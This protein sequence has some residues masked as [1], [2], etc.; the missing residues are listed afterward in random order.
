MKRK[1]LSIKKLL[2]AFFLLVIIG[3]ASAVGVFYYSLTPVSE[4]QEFIRWEITEGTSTYEIINNLESDGLIRNALIFKLYIK[5][6]EENLLIK[7]GTY[8]LSP[9]MSVQEIITEFKEENYEREK[10]ITVTFKEGLSI[11][12]M[13][14]VL[15][16]EMNI[17]EEEV[18]NAL[19]DSTYLD[20]LIEKHW[21]LTDEIK[22]N[23]LYY[24]LEGY[25]FPNTYNFYENSSAKDVI[26]KM[27]QETDRVLSKYRESI[28]AGK[29]SVHQILTLASIIQNEGTDSNSFKN[30]SSVLYNRL[31]AGQKL[32]CCT[33]AYYGAKLIQGEDDF[34]NA[35]QKVNAYNTYVVDGIP[36]GPISN[37][38]E[39]AIEAAVS[40]AKTNYYYFLSDSYLRLYFSRTFNEH[41]N[42]QNE[43]ISK[44]MWAGS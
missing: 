42:K 38:G 11:P 23:K 17:T 37:P 26:N 8:N 2:V 29:Y 15:K 1:R 9:S 14:R 27:L 22:S 39:A 12:K 6:F 24:S 7:A 10:E 20:S 18:M 34:G 4:E 5:V 19:K 33:T 35:D 32:Q 21:F 13:L 40:P 44:G 43:L 16:N 3:V 30:V 25:L 41:I 31:N 28:E 36:V